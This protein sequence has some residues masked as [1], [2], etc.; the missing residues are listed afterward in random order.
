MPK[1]WALRV[2]VMVNL[3][4]VLCKHVMIEYLDP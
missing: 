3:V 1:N 4:H 2:L